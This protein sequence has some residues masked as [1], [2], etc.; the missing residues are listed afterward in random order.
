MRAHEVWSFEHTL[1]CAVPLQFAWQFWTDVRN[2]KLDADVERVELSG[3]FAEGSGGTT[4]TRSAGP[5]TWRIVSVEPEREA[6]LEVSAPGGVIR[7][8]WTFDNLGGR[9]RM[10]QRVSIPE[11]SASIAPIVASIFEPGIPAGMQ[12]MCEAMKRAAGI[13]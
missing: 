13:E 1:D 9:T 2:W 12:K 10:T 6:V 4:F 5:I 3:P 11:E 8:R 7:F